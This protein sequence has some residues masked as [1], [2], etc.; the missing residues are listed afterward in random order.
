MMDV[1]KNHN[2]SYFDFYGFSFGPEKNDKWRNEV[3]NYFIQFED[4]S[5]ISDR[6][7]AYLSKNLEIDI[8]IDLTA[9]TSNSRS[10]IFS[11]R[12][13]PI[14]IN[15]L[16]YPGTMGA[17]YMDYIIADEVII[18]KENF[19]YYSEKVLYL[20]DCYQANMSQKDISQKKFKRSDF[21]LPENAFVYCSFNNNYK[22]TP[23]IFNIWMNMLKEVPNSILWI[24]KSNETASK[25]LKKESEARGVDPNRIIFASYLPNEEHLKRI[26]LADLFLDTFPYNAHVTASDAV[27][28]GIPIVT[29]TGNSFASRVGASILSC[30]GMKELI[31]SN[32]KEYQELGIELAIKPNKLIK[33]KDRIKDSVSKSFK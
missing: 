12:A 14:Q 9:F 6:E 7:V 26:S 13:A 19:D 33:L 21:G 10:G 28:M 23:H 30:V 2:K 24:F 8:A 22:I 15:Y 5:K 32:T 17:E 29:L 11:Y 20:P 18:P 4:V 1:F 16:G 31:T 27:R 3:K 25:N